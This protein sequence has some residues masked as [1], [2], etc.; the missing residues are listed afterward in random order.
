M[1]K[2]TLG[3]G[4]THFAIIGKTIY[5]GWEYKGIDDESIKEYSTIDLQDNYP[6]IKGFKLVTRTKLIKMG[7]D[8]TNTNNWFKN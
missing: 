3:K 6:D 8:I 2:F 7:I 4:Y 1:K 5:D